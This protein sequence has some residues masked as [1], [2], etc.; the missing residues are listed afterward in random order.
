M[1]RFALILLA[2]ASLWAG[3]PAPKRITLKGT[4]VKIERTPQPHLFL[5][6][7][8]RDGRITHWDLEL[9][10]AKALLRDGVKRGDRIVVTTIPL[11][12][13]SDSTPGRTAQAS[14]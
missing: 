10:S 12:S 1:T 8:E 11:E 7:E 4:V 5:D 6:V 3:H 14:K 9:D 13:G 2:A